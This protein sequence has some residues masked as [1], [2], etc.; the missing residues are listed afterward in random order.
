[1]ERMGMCGG[2]SGEFVGRPVI[3]GDGAYKYGLLS[4]TG[5]ALMLNSNNV[6]TACLRLLVSTS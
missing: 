5:R 3:D 4:A 2:I 1:M 6:A